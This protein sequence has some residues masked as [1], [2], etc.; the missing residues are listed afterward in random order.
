CPIS[1]R[2][3]NRRRQCDGRNRTGHKG[4]VDI[5]VN[6]INGGD[7]IAHTGLGMGQRGTG[8]PIGTGIHSRGEN[9]CPIG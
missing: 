5:G 3:I 8:D 6:R 9:S 2:A 7:H 4:G 1:H